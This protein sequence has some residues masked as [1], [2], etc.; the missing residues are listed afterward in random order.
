MSLVFRKK[1]STDLS[2]LND[3]IFDKGMITSM[4]LID[5]KKA[6]DT[7]GHDCL[8]QKLYAIGFSKRTI[9]WFKSYLSNRSFL[10]NLGNYFSQR[11]SVSCG[12]PP[13]FY[14]G[15]TLGFNMR[16]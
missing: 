7:I 2:Y 5:L 1:H 16:Q 6:F 11:A 12:V 8:L 9:N 4:I 14:F 15:A 3:K 13:R 10:V